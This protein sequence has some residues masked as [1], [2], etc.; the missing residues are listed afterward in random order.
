MNA[1]LPAG[2]A[3]ALAAGL[4]WGL[5]FI[6]PLL[7][8]GYSAAQLSA[9]RYLAFGLVALPLALAGRTGLARLRRADWLEALRLALVGNLAYYALLAAAI[10]QAGAPLPTMIIGTLPVVIAV[11]ANL[12][13]R[14]IAG[15]GWPCRWWCWARASRWSMPTSSRACAPR[16]SQRN[17]CW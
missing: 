10:Q 7:L 1:A 12:G 14:E 15:A 11:C 5:V 9:G 8:P 16:G 2:V 6:V 3:C 17:S 13:Q 4:L